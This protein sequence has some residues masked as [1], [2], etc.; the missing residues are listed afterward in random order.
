M[1]IV[2][3]H[4][5]P[6]KLLSSFSSCLMI[7]QPLWVILCGIPETEKNKNELVEETK[8]GKRER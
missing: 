3:L 2:I 8:D 7:L 6:T 4:I 1:A 5:Q